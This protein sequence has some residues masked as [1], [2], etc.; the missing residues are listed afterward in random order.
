MEHLTDAALVELALAG[1]MSAFEEL[2][3][4][5]FDRAYDFA[6]RTTRD[7]ERAAD[8]V[9]EA[10]IKAHERLGQLRD[11][12]A[13]R[14]WLFSIVR[15]ETI[16]SVRSTRRETPTAPLE[17]DDSGLN[18]LL[19]QIDPDIYDDP[20]SSAELADSAAL[21]WEAAAS[22]D[23]DT[24]TIL[25]LHVRQ[26]LSSSEIADVLDITKG[27]A[28]TRVNRMKERTGAAIATYLLIR[29]G[30]KDCEE[31]SGLVAGMALPPV[32][33]TLRKAVDRHVEGCEICPE[34]R[35]ALVA[36]LEVFAA[37]GL[38]PAPAGLQERIWQRITDARDG[39]I[40]P[41]GRRWS[42][43]AAVAVFIAVFGLASG[44]AVGFIASLST[45]GDETTS[46]VEGT[47]PD[48]ASALVSTTSTSAVAQSTVDTTAT[49]STTGTGAGGV[50]G[51]EAVATTRASEGSPTP[52]PPPATTTTMPPDTEPP[53]IQQVDTTFDEIWEED[54]DSLSCPASYSRVSDIV[55]TVVENGSGIASVT[56]SWS[57]GGSPETSVMSGGGGTYFFEFGPYPYL[58]V[59][60]NTSPGVVVTVRAVDVAGN[61][62]KD[63]VGVVLHSTAT[64]F[65]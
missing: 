43:Y 23:P 53:L 27:S 64:C 45:G 7:R 6:V 39:L 22:L 3:R 50:G 12:S 36:P 31:L 32:T 19:S 11:P 60:D 52:P 29:K 56:A 20:V 62:S 38:V 63:T 26:G 61:E 30:S 34:R 25:D 44:V 57:V 37:L 65:G 51:D 55:A 48:D 54:T 2:Y 59:P 40:P 1:E 15:R 28:Y 49:A 33:A 8:A 18:P 41:A 13:F 5:H 35:K 4:K 24:Y 58:S 46:A 21:V 14:P 9:Q 16:G 47:L 17:S 42:R 10:F